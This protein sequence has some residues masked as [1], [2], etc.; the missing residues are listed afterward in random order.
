MAKLKVRKVLCDGDSITAGYFADAGSAGASAWPVVCRASLMADTRHM[1]F[2]TSVAVSGHTTAQRIAA[3]DVSVRPQFAPQL[4]ANILTFFEGINDFLTEGISVATAQA[5]YREY[6][7]L[8]K[9]QGWELI[10]ATTTPNTVGSVNTKITQLNA[11][12]RAGGMVDFTR[13]VV[14][15]AADARLSNPSDGTYYQSDHLHPNAVGYAVIAELF[16]AKLVAL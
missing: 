1:W 9:T 3:F 8:A 6:A 16:H 11:W 7:T 15:L 4:G 14:D 12:L 2:Q 13:H 10:L 5:R